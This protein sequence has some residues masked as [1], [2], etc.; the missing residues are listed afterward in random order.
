MS[1]HVKVAIFFA[2]LATVIM[3][4]TERYLTLGYWFK[5]LVKLVVF[6]SLI[7]LYSRYSHRSIKDTINLKFRLPSRKLFVVMILVYLIVI[8]AYFIFKDQLNLEA[9][10]NSLFSKE[11]LTK[12]S[13]YWVFIYII[14]VNSFLEES[15]FRGFLFNAFKNNRM[16]VT[17]YLF[18]SM[19]FAIYH[20]GIISSWFNPLVFVTAMIGLLGAGIMLQYIEE[21]YDNL[22]ASY[23][24]HSFANIAI[25]T[26]G[27]FMILA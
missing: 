10:K 1:K 8:A 13:F 16:L 26:I 7:V 15:F 4:I 18:A 23:L 22:L 17:G 20:I 27:T 24:V 2:I 21:R 5:S 9:L 11:Q 14:I 19:M 6:G 25:N 12:D 3:S